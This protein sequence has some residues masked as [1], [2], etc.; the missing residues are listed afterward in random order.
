M[1]DPLGKARRY[2]G[3]ER[4]IS[5]DSAREVLWRRD[6]IHEA[7][8]PATACR[9]PVIL[10][11]IGLPSMFEKNSM[12]LTVDLPAR[13]RRCE[14]CLTHRRRLWTA[15]ARDMIAAARRTWFGT[16]TVAPEQRF[17]L[18]IRAEAKRLRAGGESLSSLD[19]TEQFRYLAHELHVEATRW[20]KRVRSQSGAVFRY[21]LVTEEHKDGH[22]HLHVLIHEVSTPITKRVL[23]DQWRYGFSHWRLVGDDARA[24]SYV[25]KYLAKDLRTRVRAS[26]GYG[27][28]DKVRLLTE[29][30]ETLRDTLESAPRADGERARDVPTTRRPSS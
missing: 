7:V 11:A 14:G 19:A 5:R 24:A 12:P 28:A 1:A 23:E 17:K 30:L 26:V 18:R 6:I 9:S 27:Q 20:L 13:C 15:R 16:L 2:P 3:R 4:V 22:P 10:P 8:D 21:L 29:R 25:C